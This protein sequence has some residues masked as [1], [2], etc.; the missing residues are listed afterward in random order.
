M[1]GK[2]TKQ[3]TGVL[4][5]AALLGACAPADEQEQNEAVQDTAAGGSAAA[6]AMTQAK[7][8]NHE[9]L[10]MMSDHHEGLIRM[11]TAA[12]DKAAAQSTKDDA[13]KLHTKQAA[14]RDTMLSMVQRDY[15][16]Q[17]TPRPP[18]RNQAQADS[19]N[20]LSGPEYDR[21]FYRLV[22]DH[23]REGIGMIDEHLPHLTNQA[24]R[25]MAEKMKADQQ[26]EIAEFEQKQSSIR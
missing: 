13:H 7:D 5:L 4:G 10:R 1:T 16:E 14:E 6:M 25:Q 26:K 15:Q 24:V 3:W 22:I 2:M 9:F 19:L 21:T 20:A 12:M 11:A 8:G 18:A 23:H 17:H